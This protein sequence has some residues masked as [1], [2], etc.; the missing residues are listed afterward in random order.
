MSKWRLGFGMKHITRDISVPEKSVAPRMHMIVFAWVRR[1]WDMGKLVAERNRIERH[2]V[3]FCRRAISAGKSEEDL[4]EL[5]K[6]KDQ[7]IDRIAERIACAD[8]NY[9]SHLASR[10][11]VP[12]PD[13]HDARLWYISNYSGRRCLTENALARFKDE[14]ERAKEQRWQFWQSD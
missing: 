13:P 11:K 9:L 2:F 5:K 12:S 8:F 14:I 6:I 4:I 10:L 7:Q 1:R 3:S